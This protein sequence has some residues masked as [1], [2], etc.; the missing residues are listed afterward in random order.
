MTDTAARHVLPDSPASA[1]AELS[2]ALLAAEELTLRRLVADDC[3]IVGPKGFHIS[4]EEWIGPHVDNVYELQSLEIL[5]ST[6]A[7]HDQSAVIVDLQQSACVFRGE[8]IDGL[9]RVLSGWRREPDGWQLAALQYT[10]VSDA[11]S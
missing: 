10:G 5:E 9:F 3:Q 4:K 2:R 8:Q 7:V 11:A 6:Q 1:H